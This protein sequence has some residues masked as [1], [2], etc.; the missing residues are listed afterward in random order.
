MKRF[1]TWGCILSIVTICAFAGNAIAGDIY[2]SKTIGSKKGDGSKAKPKKMLWKA[3]KNLAPG[4]HLFVAEGH[5]MG[6]G[7]KGIMPKS[8]ASN[9]IIEGGWKADFSI[10]DPFKYLSIIVPASDRQGDSDSVFKWEASNNKIDNV[11]IDGFS[12]DRGAHA[13]YYG[14]GNP[15]ANKKIEGHEDC[16]A[17][18][19]QA[20]NTKKSGSD[21]TIELIGKGSFTVRNCMLINNPWWGIYIKA[22]GAGKVIIENNLVLISQGRGIEAITG[23]G[24]GK[25]LFLIKN[26]T[27]MFGHAMKTTEG[28]AISVDPRDG[29]GKVVV[30]N[31]VLA[32]NDG[33]G[34]TVKFKSKELSLNN[35][36][37]FFNRRADFAVG[38]TGVTNADDFEDELEFNT[39]GNLH[40]MPKALAK[41]AKEWFDRY[42]ARE[43]VDMLAGDFNKNDELVTM[44]KVFGLAE[45][46]LPGYKETFASYK[47]LPRARPKFNQSRYPTPVKKGEMMDWNK[48]VLPIIGADGKFGIQSTYAK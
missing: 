21:P 2:I 48:W 23:G 37:F 47:K 1:E 44:R 43:F 42:S 24:W 41:T 11:T 38:G 29:Y 4:D 18:G 46:K 7:K 36:K 22:G 9:V 20:I 31:N 35:N 27:V 16:S 19:F 33:G 14:A 17:W 13:A 45:Y 12:I 40:E 26:N 8:T 3:I 30:E 28:R 34:V 25:P 32:V 6:Q 15:G 39:E 10:R 5:Y